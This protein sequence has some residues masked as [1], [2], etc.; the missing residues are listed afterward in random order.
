MSVQN[1]TGLTLRELSAA[2]SAKK[3]SSLE[4]TGEYLK[5]IKKDL[6]H[7]KP[8]HPYINVFGDAALEAA[9]KADKRIAEGAH[10]PL[11]GIPIAIKDN[12][13]IKGFPTTCA[14]RILEGYKATYNA[15]VIDK[16]VTDNGMVVLGKTN[17]DEFAMG[18]STETSYYGIT[19]NPWDRDRI[20]GGSS[21][22][23]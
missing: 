23:S 19:R 17:M 7:E 3:V 2:L 13:N 11:T 12:M 15:A 20:P 21:G 4:I 16:L 10:T 14:S 5:A 22:G 18:S 6:E 9:K 1:I 8:V